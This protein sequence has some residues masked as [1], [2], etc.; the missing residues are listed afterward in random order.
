MKN[1]LLIAV[2]LLG[3]LLGSGCRPSK[4]SGGNPPPIVI[5]P[6]E[7]DTI[8]YPVKDI[9]RAIKWYNSFFGREPDRVVN[10]GGS[11]AYAVYKIGTTTVILDTNPEQVQL[12]RA[13]FYWSVPN[14]DAVQSKYRELASIGTHFKGFLFFKKPKRLDRHKPTDASSKE[15][16]RSEPE[17]LRFVAEDPDGNEVGVANNPIY[18]PGKKK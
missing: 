16:H 18:P 14:P 2:I 8:I 10:G 12:K 3:V 17:A 7:Q 5:K 6:Q 15:L 9:D 11:Y 4:V 1:I 13:V